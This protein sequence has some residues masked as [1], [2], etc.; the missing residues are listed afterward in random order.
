MPSDLYRA[1][2]QPGLPAARPGKW[3]AMASAIASPS[4][5][6]PNSACGRSRGP[7]AAV[8]PAA[9]PTGHAERRTW[10]RWSARGSPAAYQTCR[11]HSAIQRRRERFEHLHHIHLAAP[12]RRDIVRH[13]ERSATR[14]SLPGVMPA[15]R[16]ILLQAH[17]RRRHFADSCQRAAQADRATQT[18]GAA[19]GRRSRKGSR[20]TTSAKRHQIATGHLVIGLHHPHRPAPADIRRAVHHVARRIARSRR[21]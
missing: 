9:Y 20:V 18:P 7:C 15:R 2:D 10:C 6:Q 11:R 21:S 14:I 8:R 17:P 19:R 1:Q 4:A 12:Q 16:K 5:P 3:R 13:R